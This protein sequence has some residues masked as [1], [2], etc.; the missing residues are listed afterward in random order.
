MSHTALL[1]RELKR[2][3]VTIDDPTI[4]REW[5]GKWII[6]TESLLLNYSADRNHFDCLPVANKGYS[7]IFGIDIGFVD[8]DAIAVLAFSDDSQ[9]T[10]LVEEVVKS[11]L[12]ISEL[13]QI[14]GDLSLKYPAHKMVIDEGGLGKKIAEEI[15]RRFT[16]PV[17]PAE[18]TRKMEN[19]SLLNDALRSGIFK[20]NKNSRFTHDSY[21]LEVDRT[22]STPDKIR[23]K[24]SFHSDICL[25]KGTW[26]TVGENSFKAIHQISVGDRVLTR[27]GYKEV[28]AVAQTA[29]M[30]ETVTLTF[31]NGRS[32]T[33]TPGHKIFTVNRGFIR[34]CELIHSDKFNMDAVCQ[35]EITQPVENGL[36]KEEKQS[37]L[38]EHNSIDIRIQ[39]GPTSET[40]FQDTGE[41]EKSL[42]TEPNGFSSTRKNLL[43]RPIFTTKMATSLITRKAICSLSVVK[44]TFLGTCKR[45]IATQKSFKNKLST[46]IKSGPSQ[47]NGTEAKR[48]D[49]G[50]ETTPSVS[51]IKMENGPKVDVYNITVDG[52]HEY[53]AEG[54]L[55]KNCDAVLYAY[56]E[57]PAYAYQQPIELPKYGSPEWAEREVSE[58]E[59]AAEEHFK[60]LEESEAYEPIFRGSTF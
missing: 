43:E 2:R 53:F 50:T 26:I 37:S 57:S 59:K 40:I 39:T 27:I 14:I 4:Q 21:L 44:N 54:I 56:R 28:L 33:C 13:A 47:N 7:F 8:A 17:E 48:A 35:R 34:A 31:S 55:V 19:Y 30:A 1:D 5:F 10:Y 16:I 20:A 18:K 32:L 42:C 22:K 58:M 9:N 46:S 52:A 25:A 6:D 36:S 24:D 51:L 11:K 15:R 12:T 41:R 60:A 3:G 23:V 29:K 45:L 38:M 49:F